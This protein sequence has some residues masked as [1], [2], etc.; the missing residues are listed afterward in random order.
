MQKL[1]RSP[2]WQ[3]STEFRALLALWPQLVGPAVAQHS[4]PHQIQRGVLQVTVSSSA[5][6]QTLT[7]E[8]L[9]ILKKIH[10]QI[11]STTSEIQAMR[12]S[13]A[14]WQQ[15]R[16]QSRPLKSPQA[17]DHPSWVPSPQ[18]TFQAFPKTADEAF[19]RWS[20][21][22]QTQMN[23]QSF[24]PECQCPCPTQELKRWP[25][26]AICMSHHW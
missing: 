15:L 9:R 1:E 26:C 17:T 2:R 23:T 4:Q 10:Q 25:A 20:H 14:R 11:P 22:I 3:A 7:F 6:A 13:T 19:R 12:F 16:R 8:R 18:K 24:C 21:Q 5:W